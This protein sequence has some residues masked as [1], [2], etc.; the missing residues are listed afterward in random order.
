MM[1]FNKRYLNEK[2]IRQ[3]Y[4]DGGHERLVEFI[5]KPDA[6]IIEDLF[7]QKITDLVIQGDSEIKIR[8]LIN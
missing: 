2:S 8:T 5:R 3:V 7:S 4:N 6:L 1:G